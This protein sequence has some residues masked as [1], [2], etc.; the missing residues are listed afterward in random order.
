[1]EVPVTGQRTTA[2]TDTG[3]EAVAAAI[4][5]LDNDGAGATAVAVAA[6]AS[7]AYSTTNKKLRAL[8]EA[9]RVESFDGPDNR[10]LWRPTAAGDNSTVRSVDQDP[11]T[12]PG[13]DP[14]PAA[15]DSDIA[16]RPAG[17]LPNEPTDG[18]A[19]APSPVDAANP[20]TG[21]D[22]DPS[23]RAGLDAQTNVSDNT[24]TDGSAGDAKPSTDEPS[25]DEPSTDK[26]STDKPSTDKPSTDKPSTDKPSTD[27][28]STDEPSTD[29][30]STDEPGAAPP[31]VS[32]TRTRSRRG[33]EQT[34]AADAAPAK[35]R[36]AGGSL[37]GAI[38]DILEAHPDQQYKVGELCK[39]VDA[40]NAGTDV[41]KASQG[42]VANAL[43]TLSGKGI[44]TRTV[45]RPATFQL[46][47]PATD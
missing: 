3:A 46:T 30:P 45:D 21:P 36:R 10:T 31:S 16:E 8:R 40:A 24:A 14:L 42:A 2:T 35:A 5:R 34:T 9:G 11:A 33:A 39:L 19:A 44:V 20:E 7:V 4:G 38:L 29:E 41:A 26:P 32:G 15:L 28:P 17:P 6:E 25:T 27:E 13:T 18:T 23:A 1:M 37:R 22:N 47:P 12:D 43:D